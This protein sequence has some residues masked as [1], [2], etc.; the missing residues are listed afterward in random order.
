MN[1]PRVVV[2]MA[3]RCEVHLDV[4]IEEGI[5]ETAEARAEQWKHLLALQER[6]HGL[7]ATLAAIYDDD[8]ADEGG[9]RWGRTH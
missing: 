9:D 3:M 1:L 6:L 2:L 5:A 7:T 8:V 4:V